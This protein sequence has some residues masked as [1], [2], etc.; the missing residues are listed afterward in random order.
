MITKTDFLLHLDA[1]MHLWAEKHNQTEKVLSQFDLHLLE[2][3]KEIEKLGYEFLQ[4]FFA[5][6]G[7]DL[8]IDR[9]Q[10]FTDG[11]FQARVDAVVFDPKKNVYDIYE[12]KSSTSIKK[13]HKYDVAFQRLVCE[14]IIPVRNVFIVLVNKEF[15]RNGDL[16]VS[17]FFTL[18]DMNDEIEK[19]RSEVASVR[20]DAWKV[21]ESGSP[22]DI[23]ECMK[24]KECPCPKLCHPELP[25]YPIFDLSRLHGNRARELMGSG[26]LAIQDIPDD[27]PLTERQQLQAAVVK[28]GK[29]QINYSAIKDELEEL[30]YPLYFLDYETF[31]PGVPWYDGYKPYQHMV[32][33]YSLHIVTAQDAEPDH[34]ECLI[35][36][37]VDPGEKIVEHLAKHIGEKGSVIVW[38][39]PFEAG[40]NREMAELYPNYRKALENINDRLFDLMEI[41]SKGH[42]IHPDFHGSASIKKVLLVLVQE[43]D[44]NYE[45][46]PISKGDDA[47]MAWKSIMLGEIE[48][49]DIPET[50]QD[51]LRYC[52]LDTMA[53]VKIWKVLEN[54]ATE[55]S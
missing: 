16:D 8:Q 35:T 14:A 42:F 1:P 54:L 25:E 37:E 10:T 29:P 12:I 47:M 38:Y 2:Q 7:V 53:M 20:E 33:Q 43:N 44:L 3:G 11:N 52:G 50:K 19:L 48:Q 15:V 21:S 40:K 45:E 24:P 34:S 32:F 5:A 46:L 26:T 39:K 31:N 49:G 17:N 18:S 22:E 36:D 27:F 6:Q 9:G 4:G 23:S 41:F 51:L 28:T 13:E 30:E 55:V